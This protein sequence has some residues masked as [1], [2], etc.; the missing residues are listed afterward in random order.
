MGA[1]EPAA[2]LVM[3]VTGNASGVWPLQV[4][5][6]AFHWSALK[7]YGILKSIHHAVVPSHNSG[8][9][10]RQFVPYYRTNI[11]ELQALYRARQDRQADCWA[12]TW[13]IKGNADEGGSKD[14][15]TNG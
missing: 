9:S 10:W 6:L 13:R 4:H 7:T 11:G 14:E 15:M 1:Q 8:G 5:S 2:Q 12:K 3:G